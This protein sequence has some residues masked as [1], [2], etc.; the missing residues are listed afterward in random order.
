MLQSFIRIVW[1]MVMAY[2]ALSNRSLINQLLRT[3]FSF[4]IYFDSKNALIADDWEITPT[5]ITLDEKIGEGAFGTVYSATVDAIV[6]AKS[7]YGKQSGGTTGFN[8][9]KNPKVAVKLL[10]G[11]QTKLYCIWVNPPYFPSI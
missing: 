10:K 11:K 1:L 8:T 2:L 7:R 6:I 5:S 3:F 9:E 4:S